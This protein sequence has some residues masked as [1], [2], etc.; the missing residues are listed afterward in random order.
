[1]HSLVLLQYKGVGD[2]IWPSET[3]NPGHSA[4]NQLPRR[5]KEPKILISF[6]VIKQA[7]SRKEQ[8]LFDWLGVLT[9]RPAFQNE[10]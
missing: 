3:S 6:T 9:K 1:M 7:V 10:C 2:H 8:E 4:T 5:V